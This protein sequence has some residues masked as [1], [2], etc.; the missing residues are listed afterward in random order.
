[1]SIKDFHLSS[2]R[3]FDSKQARSE[4]IDSHWIKRR[5]GAGKRGALL[6]RPPPWFLAIWGAQKGAPKKQRS[7][8][9]SES[10]WYG[11]HFA[12][13]SGPAKDAFKIRH[14]R[15]G[16]KA[17]RCG[18]LTKK[19]QKKQSAKSKKPIRMLWA[20]FGAPK[21]PTLARALAGP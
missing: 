15:G 13:H 2:G 6:K 8:K 11:P 9:N 20:R 16:L 14:F 12:P 21:R 4:T 3:G 1:M 17:R 5:R 7:E 10:G 19:K 18:I